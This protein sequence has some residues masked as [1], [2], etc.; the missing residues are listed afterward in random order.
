MNR[1]KKKKIYIVVIFLFF[2]IAVYFFLNTEDIKKPINQEKKVLLEDINNNKN[3]Y[4]EEKKRYIDKEI[5]NIVLV[6]IDTLRADHLGFMGYPRNTSPF[7]D[8]LSRESVVFS[9]AYTPTPS[10]NP[11]VSSLFTSLHTMQHKV[12]NNKELLDKSFVT[13]A[14]FLKLKKFDTAAFLPTRL[15]HRGDIVQGFDVI[16]LPD[17]KK[18][19]R[20]LSTVT[21]NNAIDWLDLRNTENSL[22]LWMHFWD[23]HYIHANKDVD[24]MSIKG[25]LDTEEDEKKKIIKFWIDEQKINPQI[26][27]GETEE[28]MIEAMVDSIN[29]YDT[30]ILYTDT[31]IERFYSYFEE[32][33]LNKDTLW[34]IV[35]DHGE[36]LGSHDFYMHKENIYRELVLTPIMFHF[37]KSFNIKPRIINSPIENVD[38]L[39][40]LSDIVGFSLDQQRKTIQGSSLAPIIFDEKEKIDDKN[41][42]FWTGNVGP[43]HSGPYFPVDVYIKDTSFE[44][45]VFGVQNKNYKYIYNLNKEDELYSV[46]ED[47][48]ELSNILEDNIEKGKEL[49]GVLLEKIEKTFEESKD[50]IR[51]PPIVY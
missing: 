27:L 43:N 16:N 6:I 49:K 34:I 5:K 25:F 32:N 8:K 33:D 17:L 19:I 42:F 18:D 13:M 4:K 21:V 29:K 38:V 10:T 30:D 47:P 37:P 26:F 3:I 9:N 50:I 22:F 20:Q 11:S 2:F 15:F 36:G 7:L 44:G 28:D 1:F 46:K 51:T 24:R 41:I 12:T 23:C 40:T 48:A 14:E 39:P 35:T 45:N 31:E